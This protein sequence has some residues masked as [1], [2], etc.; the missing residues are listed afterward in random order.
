MAKDS[1]VS[2]DQ[3]HVGGRRLAVATVAARLDDRLGQRREPP[4]VVG[5]ELA[6][7]GVHRQ[8][9][10]RRQ[11][12]AGRERTALAF[13]A[14][15]VV[16]EGHEHRVGVA[17]VDLAH[18]DVGRA[19]PGHAHR[20]APGLN[21]ARDQPELAAVGHWLAG[22]ALAPAPDVDWRPA[23]AGGRVRG[24]DDHRDR[25]VGHE[26]AVEQ[27][28]RL[29][30]PPGPLVI[31]Q[32]DRL[33]VLRVRIP[34]R[35]LPLRDGDRTELLAGRAEPFHVPPGGERVVDGHAA[36]PVTGGKPAQAVP[37]G[38]VLSCLRGLMTAERAPGWHPL[39]QRGVGEDA[40]HGPR[41][42]SDHGLCRDLDG[43]RRRRAKAV[44]HGEQCQVTQPEQAGQADV[45]PAGDARADQQAVNVGQLHAGIGRRE[46]D[47]A[48]RQP[49][50]A[51]AVD[52]PR[53]V[54]PSP[55][56][57]ASRAAKM[58]PH[59]SPGPSEDQDLA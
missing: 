7:A 5:G 2:A 22:M 56:I 33:P 9:T 45:K 24:R 30:D 48:C 37:L 51:G 8:R 35:P 19:D 13:G 14:E 53:L 59:G 23:S 25:A 58:P 34:G 36:E 32:R 21:S 57:A 26:R 42:A 27:V 41:R 55:V 20:R 39:T 15:P 1:A 4:H 6:S 17:V 44:D 40:G 47:R 10:A 16:L 52:P 3:D 38:P 43:R 12:A 46:P 49:P 54:M 29:G 50:R 28:Q 11:R 31:G 18:R